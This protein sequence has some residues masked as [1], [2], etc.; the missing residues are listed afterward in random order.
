MIFKTGTQIATKVRQ[1]LDLID[2]PD[3]TDTDMLAWINDALSIASAQ[4]HAMSEDY[5]LTKTIVTLTQGTEDYP[6]LTHVPALYANKIRKILYRNG[7]TI[8]PVNRLRG[9]RMFEAIENIQAFSVSDF[10]QYLLRNDAVTTGPVLQLVPVARES[11]A[12][13]H[14]WHLRDVSRLTTLSD[15]VDI[16]EF[17]LFIEAYVKKMATKDGHPDSATFSDESDRMLELMVETLSNMVPD[18]D[19]VIEPDTDIWEEHA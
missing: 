3:V 13:L 5:F 19:N 4:I 8:Y 6:L 1:D 11:G 18:E 15:A 2:E 12:Y 9:R 16:P 7:A 17:H 10:Y 14:V